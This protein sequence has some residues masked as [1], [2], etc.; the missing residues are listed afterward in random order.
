MLGGQ[1]YPLITH[2]YD[3]KVGFVV[4]KPHIPILTKQLAL[5]YKTPDYSYSYMHYESFQY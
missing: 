1:V 2:I 4:H 3:H 5:L